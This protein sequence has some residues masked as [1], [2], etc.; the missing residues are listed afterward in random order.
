METLDDKC[1]KTYKIPDLLFVMCLSPKRL[2]LLN[3]MKANPW[4][5]Q[6]ERL[7]VLL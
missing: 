2:I 3:I 5:H 7:V 6:N 4:Q 1:K